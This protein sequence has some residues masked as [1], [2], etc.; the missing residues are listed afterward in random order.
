MNKFSNGTM[1]HMCHSIKY[2]C[3]L[4][5]S[6]PII[7]ISIV[8]YAEESKYLSF[9]NLGVET[10]EDGKKTYNYSQW[11][12]MCTIDGLISDCTLDVVRFKDCPKSTKETFIFKNRYSTQNNT[13]PI[14]FADINRGKLIFSINY[15]RE[16]SECIFLFDPNSADILDNYKPISLECKMVHKGLFDNSLQIIEDKLIEKTFYYK[17]KCGFFMR[18]KQD[19]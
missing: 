11:N 17:P 13:L 4:L 16:P 18:G 14:R 8:C 19:P 1:R 6:L 2:L 3:Y 15:G 12:L 7:T 5:C 10:W 9:E